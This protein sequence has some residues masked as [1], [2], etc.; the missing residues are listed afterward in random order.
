M[1]INAYS[2]L[3][4]M[5]GE[6]LTL[7]MAVRSIRETDNISQGDMARQLN[8]TQA[9]LSDIENRRKMI[10]PKKAAEIADILGQS[11]KQFIRLAIQDLL[12]R[13]GLHYDVDLHDV[14]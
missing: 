12:D 6:R 4:E 9:Y 5:L 3:K 2:H 1:N 8:V 11:Q 7:A 13:D 14:A 10:S